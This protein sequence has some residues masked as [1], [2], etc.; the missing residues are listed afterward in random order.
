MRIAFLLT[1]SLESP[2]GLGRCFPLAREIARLGH[3]VHIVA[4]HHNYALVEQ[5]AFVK[6]GVHVHYVGQMH[7]LKRENTTEYFSPLKLIWLVVTGAV[8]LASKAVELEADVYHLGKP[9]PQNAVAGLWVARLLRKRRL[10]LDCDDFEAEANRFSGKWQRLGVAWLENNLPRVVDGL[11]VNT[12]FLLQYFRKLDVPASKMI[13]LPNAID[14]ERFQDIDATVVEAERRRLGV[15]GKRVILY[16]G[17]ISLVNHPLDLLIRAFAIVTTEIDDAVLVV[18]GGGGDLQQLKDLAEH[19]GVFQRCRFVGR[20]SGDEV[21]P[22]FKLADVSVDPVNDDLVAQ[23]RWP[24]KIMESLACGVPVV[25][26]DV[27]D[28]R[29]MLGDGCAGILVAPGD[30]R[31]LADGLIT[32]LMDDALRSDFGK[33]CEIQASYFDMTEFARN[34]VEFYQY[35]GI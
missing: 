15:T 20:I 31:A 5:D 33:A 19:L 13:H 21:L 3:D 16:V 34:L 28:R 26:G 9:H 2:Y 1:T 35:R 18:V 25:T 4:L 10:F 14:A 11:T 17:S 23:A 24:L 32:I 8:K 30:P 22:F 7:V 27:G 6:E 12:S 29:Q